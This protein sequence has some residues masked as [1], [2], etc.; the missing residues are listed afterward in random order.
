MF[1]FRP[2]SVRC[3]NGKLHFAVNILWNNK[4]PCRA[5]EYV[6]HFYREK[7]S[8]N[9]HSYKLFYRQFSFG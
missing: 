7:L 5:W 9:A 1:Y 6:G 8:T 4:H 2:K 3:L